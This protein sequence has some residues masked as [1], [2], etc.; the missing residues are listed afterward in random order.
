MRTYSLVPRPQRESR[1]WARWWQWRWAIFEFGRG[2]YG[3][4]Y[5]SVL[6]TLTLTPTVSLPTHDWEMNKWV[7]KVTN[8]WISN[9]AVLSS[10]VWSPLLLI[11]A[12]NMFSSHSQHC[13]PDNCTRILHLFCKCKLQILIIIVL[14]NSAVC[15][16][17][18]GR[19]KHLR[20]GQAQSR[21]ALVRARNH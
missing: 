20:V 1:K 10:S 2:F 7:W 18:Q 14:I 15:C 17:Q 19:R 11:S 9:I 8:Y 16:T 6:S 13:S 21:R 4:T 12:I 5:I 3:N